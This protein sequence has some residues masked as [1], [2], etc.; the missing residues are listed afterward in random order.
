VRS[1]PC[2]LPTVVPKKSILRRGTTKTREVESPRKPAPAPT[3]APAPAPAPVPA[4]APLLRS[5]MS[6]SA[7]VGSNLAAI[8]SGG[9]LNSLNGSASN[10][11][12]G[13]GGGG[14]GAGRAGLPP[15]VEALKS[16]KRGRSSSLTGR[17]LPRP[18]LQLL[19]A[20]AS[21]NRDGHDDGAAAAAAATGGF[22]Y[23]RIATPLPAGRSAPVS[24]RGS[25]ALPPELTI[26]T[27]AAG[28]DAA[29][30]PTSPRWSGIVSP[31]SQSPTVRVSSPL[32]DGGSA[33]RPVGAHVPLGRHASISIASLAD[34]TLSMEAQDKLTYGV[35]SW[36]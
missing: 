1:V 24:P 26:P 19:R 23:L 14:G 4:P 11:S 31:R 20:T 3:P 7:S 21:A 12:S 17:E 35:R 15:P 28:A 33:E 32:A 30:R 27:A 10:L 6:A 2:A 13:G 8:G 9:S 36:R 25:M 34:S 5:S 16:D 29:N 18:M 22:S